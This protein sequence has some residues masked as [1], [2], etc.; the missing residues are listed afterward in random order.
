MTTAE[1]EV[2][3]GKAAAD[4]PSGQ[5][6][7]DA[8]NA[9]VRREIRTTVGLGFFINLLVLASPIYMMQVFDRV[10]PTGHV[11]TLLYLTLIV[12]FALAVYGALETLRSRSLARVAFALEGAIRAPALRA[13]LQSSRDT[14]LAKR[15]PLVVLIA[16][17]QAVITRPRT[18]KKLINPG[19]LPSFFNSACLRS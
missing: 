16:V 3:T 14:G 17:L 10:L 6:V 18:S 8:T 13:W 5:Q 7:L 12:F 1:M 19:S 4:A 11:E 9:L 15:S 2:K